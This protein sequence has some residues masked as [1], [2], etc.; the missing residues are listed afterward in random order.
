[1]KEG[2]T[3][4][5]DP[6]RQIALQFRIVVEL[7]DQKRDRNLAQLNRHLPPISS[8]FVAFTIGKTKKEKREREKRKEKREK[9]EERKEKKEKKEKRREREER[10]EKTEG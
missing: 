10:K 2:L 5:D 3:D 1:M 7:D 4:I 9:K 6:E 8:R